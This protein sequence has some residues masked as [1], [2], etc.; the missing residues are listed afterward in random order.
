MAKRFYSCLVCHE[1]FGGEYR[2]KDEV[3]AEAGLHLTSGMAHLHCLEH[4]LG[5]QLVVGDF[6]KESPANASLWFGMGMALRRNTH[7]G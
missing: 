1:V 2:V 7:A 3:W 5:R 4:L 6:D